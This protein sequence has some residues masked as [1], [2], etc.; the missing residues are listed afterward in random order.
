M[1]GRVGRFHGTYF[2]AGLGAPTAGQVF[3]VGDAA[4]QC[5]PLTG[6][7]IRPAVYFG[8]ICGALVQSVIDGCLSLEDALEAY[9][10]RVFAHRRAYRMLR[11]LQC[12]V[13]KMPGAWLGL[14]AELAN[15]PAIRRL[16]WPR[17][18]SFGKEPVAWELPAGR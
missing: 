17:Y 11:A 8:G 16:W 10:R 14:V 12:A 15:R 7:G 9:R 4:G 2:P 6:E 18:L 13:Q 3:A 5:L 1:G